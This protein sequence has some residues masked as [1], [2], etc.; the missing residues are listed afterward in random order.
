MNRFLQTLKVAAR[1]TAHAAEKVA[2]V[3]AP[4][5]VEAG[6]AVLT[7][8]WPQVQAPAP[9][10]ISPALAGFAIQVLGGDDVNPLEQMAIMLIMGTLQSVVK[11]PQHKE[12][13]KS[14]LLLVA[15]DIYMAYGMAPAPRLGAA[16]ATQ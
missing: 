5:A 11:N 10:P 15:D 3:A 13:L 16:G 1:A 8:R 7:G 2:V 9:A 14:Q 4:V 12:A 6:M